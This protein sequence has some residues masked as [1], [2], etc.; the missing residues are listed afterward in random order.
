MVQ[1]PTRCCVS[2][3]DA[4]LPETGVESAN[5]A[6]MPGDGFGGK[7]AGTR[8]SVGNPD[9]GTGIRAHEAAHISAEA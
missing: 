7:W 8:F 1:M 6:G 9:R 2:D 3:V 5:S 4:A